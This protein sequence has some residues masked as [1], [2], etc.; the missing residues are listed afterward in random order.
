M[1]KA[2]NKDYIHAFKEV[3][4][5]REKSQT[6]GLTWKLQPL[7]V[8]VNKAF[9][10]YLCQEWEAWMCN[11]LHSYTAIGKMRRAT[12]PVVCSW[13]VSAWAKVKATSV[14]NAYKKCGIVYTPQQDLVSEDDG[15]NEEGMFIHAADLGEEMLALFHSDSED[16]EFD[17]FTPDEL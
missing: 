2:G 3:S 8:G 1:E 6:R 4:R 11:G 10:T 15:E 12:I 17:G 9:K 16:E 14:T 7:D 13:V 5:P